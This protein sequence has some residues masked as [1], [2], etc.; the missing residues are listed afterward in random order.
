MTTLLLIDFAKESI[1]KVDLFKNPQTKAFFEVLAKEVNNSRALR[2]LNNMTLAD[3]KNEVRALFHELYQIQQEFLDTNDKLQ[4]DKHRIEQYKATK[5]FADLIRIPFELTKTPDEQMSLADF[6]QLLQT[7]GYF[8]KYHVGAQ[9]GDQWRIDIEEHLKWLAQV[10]NNRYQALVEALLPLC[11]KPLDELVIE[12]E[13]LQLAQLPISPNA[14]HD[15]FTPGR[16]FRFLYGANT[17]DA[18]IKFWLGAHLQMTAVDKS[19]K[20]EDLLI[21]ICVSQQYEALDMMLSFY[22]DMH[23]M[24]KFLETPYPLLV[25]CHYGDM[26]ILKKIVQLY[27][28]YGLFNHAVNQAGFAGLCEK[29]IKNETDQ[30]VS[31]FFIRLLGNRELIPENIAIQDVT[32]VVIKSLTEQMQ[33][34]PQTMEEYAA[35]FIENNLLQQALQHDRHALLREIVYSINYYVRQT[36]RRDARNKPITQDKILFSQKELVKLLMLYYETAKLEW[37]EHHQRGTKEDFIAYLTPIL[38]MFDHHISFDLMHDAINKVVTYYFRKDAAKLQSMV[39]A[40]TDGTLKLQSGVINEYHARFFRMMRELPIEIQADT[41]N[42]YADSTETGI[43]A[44]RLEEVLPR[45]L[46]GR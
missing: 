41:A 40:F 17:P 34:E 26:T 6:Y 16:A 36:K 3:V 2:I 37:I 38:Q 19:Y 11:Y 31:R 21:A 43:S 29:C 35:V 33:T 22:Q 12:L 14:F 30:A 15:S 44:K 27:D 42:L 9:D 28:Q 8:L 25:A 18:L 39:V 7:R 24:E 10:Q 5:K 13:H 45:I 20:S 4:D 32:S 23:L 46:L 1:T